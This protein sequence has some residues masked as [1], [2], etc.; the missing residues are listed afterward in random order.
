MERAMGQGTKN[1]ATI[2]LI[3]DEDGIRLTLQRALEKHGFRLK[4]AYDE[5]DAIERAQ[6]AR[7]DLILL[8]M[9]RIPPLQVLDMGCRI[10]EDARI[11]KDVEVVVYADRA[12]ETVPEG[13]E[14]SLGPKEHAILPE[15]FD[16]LVRFLNRLLTRS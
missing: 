13:G 11:G 16:Q 12:D 10:R 14:V 3:D 2:L 8:E 5:L 15:D 9:G 1:G 4:T 7:P 6:C